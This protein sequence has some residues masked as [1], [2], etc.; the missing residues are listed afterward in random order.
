MQLRFTPTG[1]PELVR[2][3]GWFYRLEGIGQIVPRF[4]DDYGYSDGL[5]GTPRWTTSVLEVTIYALSDKALDSIRVLRDE[6]PDQTIR[7]IHD[8]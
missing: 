8:I 4:D 3:D 6:F 5:L 7:L 2:E 1:P